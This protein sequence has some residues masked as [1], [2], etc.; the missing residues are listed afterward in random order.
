MRRRVRA[1][2]AASTLVADGLVHFFSRESR[3]AEMGPTSFAIIVGVR[4]E[5]RRCFANRNGDV[6]HLKSSLHIVAPPQ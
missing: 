2:R 6:F 5:T 3:A 4:G 1:N